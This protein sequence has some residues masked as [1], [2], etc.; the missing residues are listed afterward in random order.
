MEHLAQVAL[1]VMCL[2]LQNRSTGS[3]VGFLATGEGPRTPCK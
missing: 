2:A 3:P 1:F